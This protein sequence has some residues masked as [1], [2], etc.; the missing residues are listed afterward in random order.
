MLTYAP[1]GYL[2]F[3][4]DRT[5]VAQPFDAKAMKTTGEPVPLA[6]QIGTDAV[7]L[8][9]FSVSRDGVLAYRTGESGNR[10]LWI[11]RSGKELGRARRPGRLRGAEPVPRRRPPR[12]RPAGRARG[13]GRRL[14]PR[15]RPRR[16]LALH[17]R[18]R[19]T[20]S[21]RSGS[22]TARRSCSTRTGR[23]PP[24]STR[25]RRMARATRSSCSRVEQLAVPVS[26][27]P[28]GRLLAYQVR[29]PKTGWDIFILPMTGES[30][31]RPVRRG[32]LQRDARRRSRPTGASSPMHVER[33]RPPRDLRAELPRTGRQVADLERRGNGPALARRRQGALLPGRRSEAHGRRNQRRRHAR[34]RHPAGSLPGTRPRR[35]RAQQVPSRR[36]RQR[37]LFVAPL[38]RESMTPTT[39]VLNWFAAL[40]K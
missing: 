35:Q 21:P 4:R 28:D 11:D 31:A 19:E 5:L 37:F 27:S 30:Q 24:A 34:G 23:G 39:V 15:P 1:P 13:Q 33:V 25:K 17:V 8:A 7:G 12:V 20:T 16:E 10:M 40:G 3:V 38:G 29:N 36:G 14:D 32:V 9:R 6:E 22:P 18:R 26:F 2:L